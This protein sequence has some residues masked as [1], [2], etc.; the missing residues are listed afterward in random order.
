[1]GYQFLDAAGH[2]T[3]KG[4]DEGLMSALEQRISRGDVS[5]TMC[6]DLLT[7]VET[8][9]A[10]N[11][12]Q[13]YFASHEWTSVGGVAIGGETRDERSRSR[14][15]SL[16]GLF[17]AKL[18]IDTARS[19]SP[20]PKPIPMPASDP[21]TPSASTPAA[22]PTTTDVPSAVVAHETVMYV[23]FVQAVVGPF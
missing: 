20:T 4:I 2:H 6:D 14:S 7:A 15:G 13:G 10:E 11:E 12:L 3:L 5:P 18:H 21:V 19:N 17:G 9:M 16:R 22:T 1:M 8:A 23:G